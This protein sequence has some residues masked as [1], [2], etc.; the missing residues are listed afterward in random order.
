MIKINYF[1][2]LCLAFV[3]SSCTHNM[4]LTK[5]KDDINLSKNSI[6]LFSLK[7][8]NQKEPTYQ[9]LADFV[10]F[11]GSSEKVYQLMGKGLYRSEKD[12]FNEYLLGFDLE[13]GSNK[14]NKLWLTYSNVLGNARVT[15]PLDL[16]V[17]IKPNSVHYLGHMDVVIRAKNNDNEES[18]AHSVPILPVAALTGAAG[19]FNS[20]CDVFIDDKFDEDMKSFVTE[21]PGLKK[22]K[23]EKSILPQWIRPENRK[24]K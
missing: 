10:F 3:M 4:A 2:V 18:I 22:A 1:F 17:D 19:F 23:V 9:P 8:S 7:I 16:K 5:G 12:S 6:A 20:T 24:A 11:E 15:I 21:Y 14:L 13:P